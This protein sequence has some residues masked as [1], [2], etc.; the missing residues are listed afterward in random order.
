ME[1]PL[2]ELNTGKTAVIK[3]IDG[4][5]NLVRR[6][7]SLDIR[8]DQTVRRVG[9]GPF[10]GPVIVEVNRARV[11]IGKGLAAQ[12]VVEELQE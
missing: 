2:L 10:N 9:S 11:A 8:L 3:E 6:L 12:V 7:A 4:G 1:I 5:C